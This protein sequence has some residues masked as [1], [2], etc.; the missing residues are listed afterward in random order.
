MICRNRFD[1]KKVKVVLIVLV[2]G[3]RNFRAK[4]NVVRSNDVADDVIEFFFQIESLSNTF[5]IFGREKIWII[6][7]R[8]RSPL[9]PLL[10]LLLQKKRFLMHM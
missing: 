5:S 1:E 9:Q 2:V 8:A 7:R 4:G 6:I 10:R 3:A